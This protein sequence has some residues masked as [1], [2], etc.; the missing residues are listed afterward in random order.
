MPS[1]TLPARAMAYTSCVQGSIIKTGRHITGSSS[2]LSLL[3]FAVC[4]VFGCFESPEAHRK[5]EDHRQKQA[6]AELESLGGEFSFRGTR[7]QDLVLNLSTIEI[8]NEGLANVAD[9]HTLAVLN[10]YGNEKVTDAGLVHLAGLSNLQHLLLAN[11]GITDAGMVHLNRLSNLRRLNVGYTHLTGGGFEHL[12]G[13]A[14][15]ESL[16]L[17]GT[18]VTDAGLTHLNGLTKLHTLNIQGTQVTDAG[19]SEL[20]K[21]L[22][23]C[24]ISF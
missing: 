21:A 24:D 12:K 9:V 20:K 5:E 16:D 4:G 18:Q 1:G 14:K 15:L 3:V 17:T 7:G 10:L 22:P 11:T 8:N 23:D 19:V 2:L 13:L 6:I